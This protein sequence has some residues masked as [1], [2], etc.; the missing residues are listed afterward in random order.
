MRYLP[1]VKKIGIKLTKQQKNDNL[2]LFQLQSEQL[3]RQLFKTIYNGREELDNNY[4]I[5]WGYNIEQK[6][7]LNNLLN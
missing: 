1:Y 6:I 3:K 2:Q 4:T 7:Y 5:P